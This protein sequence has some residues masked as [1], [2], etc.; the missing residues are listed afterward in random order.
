VDYLARAE[1]F[2]GGLVGALAATQS[3]A[4]LLMMEEMLLRS[5][6]AIRSR[7]SLISGSRRTPIGGLFAMMNKLQK[8]ATTVNKVIGCSHSPLHTI[9][10]KKRHALS[11]FLKSFS[12][13]VRISIGCPL[14]I[15]VDRSPLRLQCA[16]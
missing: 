8:A 3:A 12:G 6:A 4:I 10:Q 14:M 11:I 1:P 7:N 9:T 5:V 15:A 13:E 2:F 16:A